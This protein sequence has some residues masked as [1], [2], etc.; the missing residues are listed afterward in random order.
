M[1]KTDTPEQPFQFVTAAYLM[2]IEN[3]RAMTIAELADAVGE[4]SDGSIFYH[5]FQTLGQHHF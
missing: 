2:R 4:A 1:R 5:T 3:Q